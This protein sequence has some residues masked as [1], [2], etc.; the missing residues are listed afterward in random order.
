MQ[1][2]LFLSS[3]IL[4]RLIE[5]KAF[6][7]YGVYISIISIV[8]VVISGRYELA[9]MIPKENKTANFIIILSLLIS[10]I[11]SVLLF[12]RLHVNVRTIIL[13]WYIIGII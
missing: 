10:I 6:G 2:I 7:T 9:I 13:Y 1:I 11:L 3:P 4:T 5:P 12:E 8:S